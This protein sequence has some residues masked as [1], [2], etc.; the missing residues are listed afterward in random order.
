MP[1]ITLNPYTGLGSA[2]AILILLVPAIARAFQCRQSSVN[3]ED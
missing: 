2:I 3:T 1:N